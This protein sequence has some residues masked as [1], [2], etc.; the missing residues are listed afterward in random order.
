[1]TTPISWLLPQP[2]PG[3]LARTVK[4][5]WASL[6]LVAVELRALNFAQRL[7]IVIFVLGLILDGGDL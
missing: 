6:G 7:R 1:M 2:I 3:Q 4:H 5:D